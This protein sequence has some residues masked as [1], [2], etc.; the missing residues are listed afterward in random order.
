MELNYDP[1]KSILWKKNWIE[2]VFKKFP[3]HSI[4]LNY[5]KNYFWNKSFEQNNSELSYLKIQ[6]PIKGS[7]SKSFSLRLNLSQNESVTYNDVLEDNKNV[8]KS[9]PA[10]SNWRESEDW[11]W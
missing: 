1:W 8:L 6:K 9:F 10:S 2:Q 4:K 5:T 7:K 11:N 3:E